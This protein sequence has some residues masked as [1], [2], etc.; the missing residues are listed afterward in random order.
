MAHLLLATVFENLHRR[1]LKKKL[2]MI[3]SS[4]EVSA[5]RSALRNPVCR[6][7]MSMSSARNSHK[8]SGDRRP[9]EMKSKLTPNLI[10]SLIGST[11]C[12]IAFLRA[13]FFSPSYALSIINFCF[14]KSDSILTDHFGEGLAQRRTSIGSN[15]TTL[16]THFQRWFVFPFFFERT[17]TKIAIRMKRS[18]L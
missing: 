18:E 15:C 2:L 9:G 10:F 13:A 4:G 11:D 7:F 16:S 6:Q 1:R 14:P 17:T 12:E 8:S 5:F 3:I